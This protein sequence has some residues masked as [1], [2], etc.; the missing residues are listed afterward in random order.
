MYKAINENTWYQVQYYQLTILL[1]C[2]LFFIAYT[3]QLIRY[4]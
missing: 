2:P 4:A 3:L 1:L